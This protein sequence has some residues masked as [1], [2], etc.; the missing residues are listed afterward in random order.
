MFKISTIIL[1]IKQI[2]RRS[3]SVTNSI[4]SVSNLQRTPISD[5][6]TL[7]GTFCKNILTCKKSIFFKNE[8]KFYDGKKYVGY[9]NIN[10]S[11]ISNAQKGLYPESWYVKDGIPDSLGH[12]PLK[13]HLMI[14][15]LEMKD[16]IGK[17]ELVKRDK[18]Y[19]TMVMQQLLH[20]AKKRGCGSRICLV[21]GNIGG[22][23]FHPAKFYNKMG[24]D[25][26]PQ[27]IEDMKRAEKKYQQDANILKEQGYSKSSI[28][29]ILSDKY[30]HIMQEAN[31]RHFSESDYFYMFLTNPECIINYPI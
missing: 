10:I 28:E 21:A 18:K 12:Y 17:Q 6:L 4:G 1:P 27:K 26:S 29:Q 7:S 14:G 31:G 11:K 16:R 19:G 23:K 20:I 22:T 30:N 2:L 25:L 8:Y 3:K 15:E 5:E 9:A 24:F 13:P